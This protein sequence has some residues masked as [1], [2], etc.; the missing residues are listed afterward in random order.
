MKVIYADG[1]KFGRVAVHIQYEGRGSKGTQ[2]PSKQPPIKKTD[3]QTNNESE[4][5][6]LLYA[7]EHVDTTLLVEIRMDSLNVVSWMEGSFKAKDPRMHE[8]R[9]LAEKTIRDGGLNVHL[10]WV[11]RNVN[12]AGKRLEKLWHPNQE[13][14]LS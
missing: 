2:I 1:D 11:R 8:Y 12:E 5:E 13:Y 10:K 3:A 9:R 4:W 7:L 14:K 6:A